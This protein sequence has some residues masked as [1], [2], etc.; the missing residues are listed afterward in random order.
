M[1][2]INYILAVLTVCILVVGMFTLAVV[3][4]AALCLPLVPVALA[5]H[6]GS[7]WWMLLELPIV[8]GFGFIFFVKHIEDYAEE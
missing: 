5:Y 6:F 7:L 1:R 2:V 3:L 8:A 4:V